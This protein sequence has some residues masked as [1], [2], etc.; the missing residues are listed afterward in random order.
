MPTTPTGWR[1]TRPRARS[2]GCSASPAG[3]STVSSRR[4]TRLHELQ[5]AATR[6][7]ERPVIWSMLLVVSANVAGVLVAGER[8]RRWPP[9]SRRGRRL[10]AERHRRVD[11]RVRRIQLGARRSGRPGRRGAAARAGDASR[12]RAALRQSPRGRRRRRAR[13]VSAMSRFAYPRASRAPARPC[14]STSI[15]RFPPARRSPSSDR[16]APARRRSPSCCA[17]LYDPQSGAIEVDGVDIREF[18]LA[19]W[20]SR[21]TAVF[22]DFIRLELPLRDNVAPAG[23]PDDVV[24]AALESAGAANLADPR[25]GAGPR[26]RRRHRPVGR[27][28]AARRARPRAG[29]RHARRRRRAARRADRAARRARGSGDLRSP[30]RRDAALH[31]HPD[32]ASLLHGPPC[33][34]HLRARARPRRSSSARTTS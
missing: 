31:D 20:R 33:R 13:F 23:A 5:Y 24:R 30:A 28:M 8:R 25:H 6:L 4:R 27:P 10:R 9:Q 22:Q 21:V 7:R 15:S 32:L 34:S 3:R 17:G 26:V 11:D 2:C 1:W 19:S 29:S 18:D 12:R 14:S 16:T